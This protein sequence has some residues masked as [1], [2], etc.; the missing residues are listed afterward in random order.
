MSHQST[1]FNVPPG[2]QSVQVRILDSTTRIGNIAVEFLME[3]PM[4]SMKHMPILPSWSFLIE[5]PSG[6]KVLY[7]LGVPRDWHK[8]APVV[9]ER[10][11][12]SGWK[13]EVEEEVIEILEK[14]GIAA[15]EISSIIWRYETKILFPSLKIFNK[16]Q[17]ETDNSLRQPLALGP[18]WGSLEISWLH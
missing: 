14:G 4:E 17:Q 9:A 8:F 16:C 10:L 7:D 1:V 13:I 6:Q 12:E 5:H 11:K 2:S 3:P 18:Y 15:S